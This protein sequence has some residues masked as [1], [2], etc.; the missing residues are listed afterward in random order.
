MTERLLQFIWQLQ[1]FNPKELQTLEGERLYIAD[2][3]KLNKDQGPDFSTAKIQ[4]GNTIW[5]GN[6]EIHILASDWYKHHHQQD[7]HYSNVILHVVWEYDLEEK[8]VLHGIPTLEL[9]PRVA[10]ILLDRY[11]QMMN[12]TCFVPCEKSLGYVK[13]LIWSNWKDRLLVERLQRKSAYV[14]ELLQQTNYHWEETFWWMIAR[15]FGM[16]VNADAFESI[17]RS[18]PVNL[19]VRHKNQIHQL[20]ALLFGQAGLLSRR[21]TESY[22]LLLQKEYRFLKKKYRLKQVTVSLK[23]LR[24][25][26]S[27]FPSVRLA[28]LAMLIHTSNHLLSAIIEKNTLDEVKALLNVTANDYW[29]YHYRFDEE[30]ERKVKSLG[31]DMINNILIN[32][33]IPVL[34]AYGTYRKENVHI[35]KVMHWMEELSAEK[36]RVTNGWAQCGI[37]SKNALDSQ[38]LLELKMNYCDYKRCLDCNVGNA[39]LKR[40]I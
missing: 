33:I 12:N 32:T 37:T 28:Q 14:L 39:L 21:L 22:P 35:A 19:L 3:G 5:S 10:S 36:N 17:A 34:F 29:H 7:R 26:P 2:P 9:Q 25:R 24:M 4:V 40:V 16:L 27:S 15:S 30:S 18:I 1:Y 20:E 13:D 38:A 11:E 8:S 31:D 6:I 23:F